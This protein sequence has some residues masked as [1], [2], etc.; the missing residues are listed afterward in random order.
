[1]SVLQYKGK[2]DLSDLEVDDE[3]LEKRVFH[4]HLRDARQ[5]FDSSLLAGTSLTSP[6]E[7]GCYNFQFLR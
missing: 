6:L 2:V 4:S 5:Y 1:M 3:D 7:H